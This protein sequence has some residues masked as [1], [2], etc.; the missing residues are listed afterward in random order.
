MVR[1]TAPSPG[2]RRRHTRP[3]SRLRLRDRCQPDPP[4]SNLVRLTD[5]T[6]RPPAWRSADRWAAA[7]WCAPRSPPRP[8]PATSFDLVTSFDVLYA[9]GARRRARGAGGDVPRDAPWRTRGGQR[10]GHGHAARR[11]F[12]AQPRGAPLQRGD[13]R[14][15]RHAAGFAIER[16]TYTNADVVSAAAGSP[17]PASIAWPRPRRPTRSIEIAVPG[18]PVNGAAQRAIVSG[19]RVA[20]PVQQSVG[21]SLLAWRNR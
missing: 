10:R 4:Y 5:S 11:P 7:A 20:A 2:A 19:K 18:A 15:G 6:S 8:S 21:S 3:H 16:L 9:L 14:R 1:H 17:K 13:A 12:G